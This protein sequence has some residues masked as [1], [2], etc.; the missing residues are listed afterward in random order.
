M[1]SIQPVSDRCTLPSITLKLLIE[2]SGTYLNVRYPCLIIFVERKYVVGLHLYT[3]QSSCPQFQ[4]SSCFFSESKY[5]S[6]SVLLE[7]VWNLGVRPCKLTVNYGRSS[8]DMKKNQMIPGKMDS[9]RLQFRTT[10]FRISVPLRSAT[11]ISS[12]PRHRLQ[13]PS[14]AA[15]DSFVKLGD[16]AQKIHIDKLFRLLLP[17]CYYYNKSLT[18]LRG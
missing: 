16:R 3:G 11:W 1:K 4:C 17:S 8:G 7:G 9:T 5:I 18:F 12:G 14:A 15:Q 10:S 6:T 2:P 13:P